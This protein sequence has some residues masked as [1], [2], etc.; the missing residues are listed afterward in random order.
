MATEKTKNA[1]MIIE[2]VDP[3]RIEA[4][5]AAMEELAKG[6]AEYLGGKVAAAKIM[7]KEDAVLEL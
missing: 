3:T 7:T 6:V 4:L 2:C 5:R 1:F